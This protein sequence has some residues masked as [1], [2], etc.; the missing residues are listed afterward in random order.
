[1]D[2]YEKEFSKLARVATELVQTKAINVHRFISG[3]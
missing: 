2:E 1:M 3:L